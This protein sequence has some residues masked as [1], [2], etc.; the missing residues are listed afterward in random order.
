[1]GCDLGPVERQ[2]AIAKLIHHDLAGLERGE[3]GRQ[4]VL[5]VVAGLNLTPIDRPLKVIRGA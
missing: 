3:V 4:A 1:M 5:R 2:L